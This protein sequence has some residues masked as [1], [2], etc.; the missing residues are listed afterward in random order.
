[1]YELVSRCVI[2]LFYFFGVAVFS[3]YIH[4][5]NIFNQMY[6]DGAPRYK[7]DYIIV[8]AGTAGQTIAAGL[9][10]DDV[11]ILEAGGYTTSLLDVPIFTPILQKSDF[12]WSYETTPQSHSC[13]GLSQHRSRWPMGKGYGG[14][15]ILNNMIWNNGNPEDYRGWFSSL[16]EYNYERDILPY[17]RE[18]EMDHQPTILQHKT[19]LADAFLNATKEYGYDGNFQIPTLTQ[20][21][22]KRW[23]MAHENHQNG[24]RN[25]HLVLH[26]FVMHL[27]FDRT[28]RNRVTGL[29]YEK[30]GFE[31]EVLA[32]KAV[33][34]S[35]GTIGTPLILL[36]SGIGPQKDLV[37][38]SAAFRKDLPVGMN[39]QDHVT[40]GVDLILLN[41]TLGLRPWEVFTFESIYRYLYKG[42]GPL[43]MNGCEVIGFM[44]TTKSSAVWDLGF[45]VLPI[46]PSADAGMHFKQILNIKESTWNQYFNPLT[47]Q[48]TVSILPIVL[49]PKSRGQVTLKDDVILIDPKYL[50]HDDDVDVIVKGIR[51]LEQ[52]IQMPSM[53]RLGAEINPKPFPG[54]EDFTFASNNY[55]QCYVRHLT[56]TAFHPVGTCRMGASDDAT[57]VVNRDFQV[58]GIENLFVVDASVMPN[59]PSGNPNAVVAMLAKKFLSIFLQNHRDKPTNY[60]I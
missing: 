38:A 11:L 23:T 56:L 50:S 36:S 20:R 42:E 9:P 13:F 43:T 3:G 47:S 27:T 14:S 5:V 57:S 52:L 6:T 58:I 16:E 29:V 55:W 33:I 53:K 46:G 28:S 37:N 44:N 15:Q 41:D 26:A 4:M 59:L 54:C 51:I 34:L 22:G 8:G 31:F 24:P 48:Q 30:N 12:D 1:M 35:A 60:D 32:T 2:V 18:S 10:S 25:H 39:L 19:K 40:T 17:F 49:H 21:N 45:M 7:Y